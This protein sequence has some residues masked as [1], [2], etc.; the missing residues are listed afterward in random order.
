MWI[1]DQV[2]RMAEQQLYCK[3]FVPERSL[4]VLGRSNIDHKEAELDHCRRDEVPV[5]KRYGGGGTVLLHAGCVVVSVGVWMQDPFKNDHYFRQLNESV[6]RAIAPLLPGLAF[7]QRGFSDLVF[8]RRKFAGTS[9]FRS[10]NYLLYQNSILVDSNIDL[11]DTY[12]KHPTKEPD[13]R[14][15]RS[16][17]DFLIGLDELNRELTAAALASEVD[18]TLAGHVRTMLKA[19]LGAVQ[20]AHLPHLWKRC[21]APRS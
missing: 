19:D 6:L 5:L 13:Y 9:L 4:V 7:S 1:D 11:I 10:R 15:G 12:L 3:V 18:E 8:E 20:T 2:M 17:H 21:G 16:H 14:G